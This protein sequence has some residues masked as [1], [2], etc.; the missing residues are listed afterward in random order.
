MTASGPTVDAFLWEDLASP[1]Q[2]ASSQKVL[3][4]EIRLLD[5][6]DVTPIREYEQV[7]PSGMFNQWPLEVLLGIHKSFTGLVVLIDVVNNHRRLPL[8]ERPFESVTALAAGLLG[9]DDFGCR[10][11]EDEFVL[12][13]T[14]LQGGDAQRCLNRI[15]ERLWEHQQ[16]NGS[17][18]LLFTWSGLGARQR[19][20]SE[21]VAS[22]AARMNHMNRKRNVISMRSV[23]EHRKTV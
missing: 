7:V 6:I 9:E 23:N 14:G 19:P 12:I 13:F 21:A 18:S 15:S 8:S 4:P 5:V 3:H 10:T 20:L 11:T 22:A 2:S 17:F 1:L 16:S